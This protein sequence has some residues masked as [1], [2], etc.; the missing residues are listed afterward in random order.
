MKSETARLP[1]SAPG[2]TNG[3]HHGSPFDLENEGAYRRWR[4]QKLAGYP[5]SLDELIVPVEDPARLSADEAAALTSLCRRAN[6]AVYASGVSGAGDKSLPLELGA[7]L[8][9]KRIDKPLTTDEDGVSE[10]AVSGD[11]EKQSYIP[12]TDRALGWH[13]DGTYN[14]PQR[15][16]RA[17]LLHCAGAAA[18]GGES[19]LLD[20]DI[21]Y[22][23]LRDENPDFIGALMRPDALTIPAN[24]EGG[25]ERRSE[26]AG[27]AFAI[28]P[29][30]GAL[31]LRY[32]ARKRFVSWADDGADDGAV[33]GG[34]ECLGRLFTGDS[35]YIHRVTLKPGW[36]LVCNNVLHGRTAF[37]DG[38]GEAQ[39]RLIYRVYYLDRIAG[40]GYR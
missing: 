27:P 40:T 22:I 9:L 2:A 23:H 14:P 18:S 30:T 25:I 15:R 24:I 39:K 35:Q 29:E 8:G 34:L 3:Q 37:V 7:R 11:A 1:G 6:M 10:L 38:A 20:P 13:T 19:F 28:D 33:K 31:H 26:Q 21:A 36:G 17:L 16:V 5:G 4:D 12:Y 32:T